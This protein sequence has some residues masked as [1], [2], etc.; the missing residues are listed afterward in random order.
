VWIGSTAAAPVGSRT[1]SKW[2]SKRQ[3]RRRT[4]GF[5]QGRARLWGGSADHVTYRSEHERSTRL[6]SAWIETRNLDAI[7]RHVGGKLVRDPVAGPALRTAI[8]QLLQTY[9]S[10]KRKLGAPAA[11]HPL[12]VARKLRLLGTATLPSLIAAL[13]HDLIEDHGREFGFIPGLSEEERESVDHLMRVLTRGES[14]PYFDYVARLS[15][16]ETALL[17][18]LVDRLDNT[19]D[20][21]VSADPGE[22]EPRAIYRELFQRA[23]L[24]Q[25]D[26]APRSVH[27]DRIPIR[28]SYRLFDLFKSLV[29]LHFVRRLGPLPTR[30]Q[31][32]VG[33]LITTAIAEAE[34]TALHVVQFH[35]RPGMARHALGELLAY[36]ERFWRVTST[37]E[38][39]SPID[40]LFEGFDA[41]LSKRDSGA[42]ETLQT[43][44]PR[45]LMASLTMVVILTRFK[46]DPEFQGIEGVDESGV[47]SS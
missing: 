10:A 37:A 40:G 20:L 25:M 14:E 9:G 39:I 35:D 44:L 24:D 28:S 19:Y 36:G 23:L 4:G 30:L 13:G 22:D 31:I 18:K 21:R 45:M 3:S 32:A 17:I 15:K 46:L 11:V 12:R 29:L 6:L 26:H 43:D 8:D 41:R 16:Q 1:V 33:K 2:A 47:R 5:A 42:L 34:L 27:P 38:H 7:T